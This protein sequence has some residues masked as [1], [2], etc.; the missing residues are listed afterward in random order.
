MRWNLIDSG[1]PYRMVVGVC[2][3]DRGAEGGPP[4]HTAAWLKFEDDV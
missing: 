4:L 1:E 3:A 2:S